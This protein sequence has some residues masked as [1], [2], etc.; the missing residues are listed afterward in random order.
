MIDHTTWSAEEDCGAQERDPKPQRFEQ[1]SEC[2]VHFEAP[3]APSA[4][5]DLVDRCGGVEG[6]T[7]TEGNVEVL[8]RH[9]SHV[10]LLKLSQRRQVEPRHASVAEPFQI[11]RDVDR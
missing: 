6:D 11:A 5:D 2:A 4:F 3:P 8:E 9:S 1:R 7:I 10:Q